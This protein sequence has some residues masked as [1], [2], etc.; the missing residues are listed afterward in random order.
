MPLAF[1]HLAERS[2]YIVEAPF[3]KPPEST[4]EKEEKTFKGEPFFDTARLSSTT[5]DQL[6]KPHR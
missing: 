2:I 6:W 1:T 4:D 3:T 5:A